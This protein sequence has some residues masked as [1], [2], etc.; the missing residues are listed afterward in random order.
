MS[1]LRF[2]ILTVTLIIGLVTSTY[3][4]FTMSLTPPP[5]PGD[6][7]LITWTP[8]VSEG[9]S[10][11]LALNVFDHMETV[12]VDF[13]DFISCACVEPESEAK[14]RTNKKPLD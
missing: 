11:V 7:F 8:D 12:A 5:I 2:I 4:P 14:N 1:H 3:D 13:Q 6:P 9:A 10:V